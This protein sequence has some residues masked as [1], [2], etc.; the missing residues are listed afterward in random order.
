MYIHVGY[1]HTR[2]PSPGEQTAPG[3]FTENPYRV[4][5]GLGP[6]QQA[7]HVPRHADGGPSSPPAVTYVRFGQLASTRQVRHSVVPGYRR[8]LALATLLFTR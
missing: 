7:A 4:G 1:P 8:G 2:A 6:L 5:R 3:R